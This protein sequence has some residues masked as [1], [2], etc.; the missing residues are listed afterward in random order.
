MFRR[1]II[2]ATFLVAGLVAGSLVAQAQDRQV[3]IVTTGGSFEQNLRQFMYEPFTRETGIRVVPVSASGADQIARVQ[4]MIG[5]GRVTWDIYFS[6]EIQAASER[7]R[8]LTEDLTE[9]CAR[10]ADRA[11]LLPGACNA[12][13]VLSAYGTTLI[14]WNAERFPDGGPAGWADFWN[15]AR[16]P[17]PRAFPNFND[18]WRVMAAALMADGVPPE[19]IFPI[20]VERALRKLQEI[21]PHVGLWWRTG[22]QST[23]GFR[24][25]EYVVG[26]IWQTRASVLRGEG[27]RIA[28]TQNQGFLIGD[29][30]SLIR[31]APNRDSA[32]RFLEYYLSAT[33][34][35]AQRCER[36]TCTPPSRAAIARMSAGARAMIPTS[37]AALR[38][39]V[40][41]DAAWINANAAMLLE[42]WNR[43]IAQ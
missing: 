13:G 17:G 25:A 30:M 14:A 40:L 42:R 16:F 41:P 34:G 8:A 3:V 38:Q 19:R 33:D 23:Q 6:G 5:S 20:D 9:F 32:L 2:A 36:E 1:L 31:G 29:R 12:S 4:A 37:D 10:F 35:Q 22:D 39:L 15:I 18:P 26:L 43:W 28:W 11:D 21:R 7:H 24:N 27:R